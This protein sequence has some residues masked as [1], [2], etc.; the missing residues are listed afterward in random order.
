MWEEKYVSQNK[1][2]C[3]ISI[4]ILIFVSLIMLMRDNKK[5]INGLQVIKLVFRKWLV[6]C[7]YLLPFFVSIKTKRTFI[8]GLIKLTFLKVKEW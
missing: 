6:S 5:Y 7:I 1:C 2:R 8:Y 4:L 3:L